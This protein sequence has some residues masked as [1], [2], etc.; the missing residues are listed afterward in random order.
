MFSVP[1]NV[2]VSR[3]NKIVKELIVFDGFFD[4]KD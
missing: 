3:Y 2:V 4:I 1:Q